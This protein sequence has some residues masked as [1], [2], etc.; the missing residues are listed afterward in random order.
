VEN[1]RSGKST[2]RVWP[3]QIAKPI[4]LCD[5]ANGNYAIHLVNTG[6]TRKTTIVGL[7]REL[8]TLR[9]YLT[10]T[11]HGMEPG[12]EIAVQDGRAE[13][14]VESAKFTTLRGEIAT[15]KQ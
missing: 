10:D 9:T 6:A 12:S 13:F 2:V 14:T 4:S 5:I 8:K 1:C 3:S 7:P 15:L 11:N